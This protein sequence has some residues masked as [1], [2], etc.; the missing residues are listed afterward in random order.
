MADL[1]EEDVPKCL[2]RRVIVEYLCFDE[3]DDAD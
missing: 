1:L 2:M 3:A